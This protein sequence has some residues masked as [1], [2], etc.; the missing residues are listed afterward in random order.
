MPKRRFLLLFLSLLLLPACASSRALP[1]ETAAR[2]ASSSN[3]FG[4]ALQRKLPTAGP[5]LVWS[6]ASLSTALAMAWAGARGATATE[7]GQALRLGPDPVGVTKSWGATSRALQSQAPPNELRIANRLFGERSYRFEPAYLD[8][9]AE[10]EQAPL[11][12][13]D[14]RGAPDAARLRINGWVEAQ[15][16]AR[17]KDLLA[18]RTVTGETTLVLVNAVYFLG[19]WEHG[20]SVSGTAPAPFHVSPAETKNVPTMNL[21]E[22]FPFVEER[23]YKAVELPYRG[24]ATSFVVVVPT[25][26]DGLDALESS[27]DERTLSSLV[28]SLR[29]TEVAVSLPKLELG[30]PSA[31]ALRPSLEA[32]GI[33]AAFSPDR[34]DFTGIANPPRRDDRLY[35]DNVF[36]KAFIRVDEKGT[37]AAAASAVEMAY[38]A[39]P[40]APKPELVADRPFLFFLRDRASGLV[41]FMGR[42][43]DPSL[44]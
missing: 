31:L 33:M 10:A 1:P 18:P 3:A 29:D 8:L 9:L 5:N 35:V 16:N 42:V 24:A 28:A 38:A 32:L 14:F 37:E 12:A 30:P 27:F 13:V 43:R 6:P 11:E 20:F 22:T 26:I 44:G 36:H 41:L 40:P 19:Q 21:T 23:A 34:A 25:A 39:G 7:L 15:T 4:F 17:V 2:V